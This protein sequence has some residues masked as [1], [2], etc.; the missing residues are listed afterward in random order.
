MCSANNR[1]INTTQCHIIYHYLHSVYELRQVRFSSVYTYTVGNNIPCTSYK[2]GLA[3]YVGSSVNV[4][5]N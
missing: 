3:T 4:S 1:V 2:G 5:L